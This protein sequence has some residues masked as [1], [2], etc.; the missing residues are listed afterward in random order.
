MRALDDMVRA[1][2]ILY[3]GISDAPAWKVAQA[4]TLA[5]LRGWSQFAGLQIEYNLAE[6]SSERDLLPM[7]DEF[8]LT[9]TSWS[10]L[11]GGVLSGK[12][13]LNEKDNSR[14]G[15]QN[16]MS[17]AFLTERNLRIAQKVIDIARKNGSSPSQIALKWMVQKNKNIIPI[18]G[19]KLENQLKDNLA[20]LSITISDQDMSE[21][22]DISKIELGFPHDF[23]SQPFIRSLVYGETYSKIIR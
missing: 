12:Y 7:A 14:F 5:E 11:A 15:V 6:R 22:D 16:P 13:N 23:L 4:N 18:I 2:K 9:I 3:I 21:L 1:G 20:C 10:P 8:G 19:A 17:N